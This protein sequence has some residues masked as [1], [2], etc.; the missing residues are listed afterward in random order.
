MNL[1]VRYFILVGMIP[2]AGIMGLL[3]IHD[4]LYLQIKCFFLIIQLFGLVIGI[5]LHKQ[6]Y[7]Y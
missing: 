3:P 7:P 5:V 1:K 2:V 6:G 4:P